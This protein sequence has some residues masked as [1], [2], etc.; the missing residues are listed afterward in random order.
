M[1]MSPASLQAMYGVTQIAWSVVSTCNTYHF[2]K[3]AFDKGLLQRRQLR[4][5]Y[6]G[7]TRGQT[8]QHFDDT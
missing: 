4:A 6:T 2:Y 5:E 8:Q 7:N 1:S 3:M